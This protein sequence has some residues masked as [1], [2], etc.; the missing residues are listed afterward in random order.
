MLFSLQKNEVNKRPNLNRS[1]S[2]AI[3]DQDIKPL[4]IMGHI[5]HLYWSILT[6]NIW[7]SSDRGDV[8]LI[9]SSGNTVRSTRTCSTYSGHFAIETVNNEEHIYWV[10]IEKRLVKR[11]DKNE[12]E[13]A[14]WEPISILISD[15]NTCNFFFVGKA[16]NDDAKVTKYDKDWKKVDDIH[17]HKENR[18]NRNLFQYPAYLAKNINGDLCVSDNNQCVIVVKD[19]ELRFKYTGIDQ[20]GF[21]P[22]GICTDSLKQILIVD[23]SSR[24]I[25]IINEEGELLRMITLSENLK[26]P[27][28]LCIDKR[29]N[30]L[31]GTYG[32]ILMYKY[33]SEDKI[34]TT[35]MKA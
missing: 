17:K 7:A 34:T 1:Y 27:R 24:S 30:C 16:M 8:R 28:G 11:D 13:T 21:T 15:E 33:S 26:E 14:T 32:L 31:V 23:S 3:P 5:S 35:A 6:D 12:H 4:N 2:V 18:K 29:G 22:Y 9:D 19:K 20:H 25:H 10:H